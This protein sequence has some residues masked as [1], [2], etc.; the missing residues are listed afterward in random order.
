MSS[1]CYTIAYCAI[2]KGANCRPVTSLNLNEIFHVVFKDYAQKRAKN[3]V[4]SPVFVQLNVTAFATWLFFELKM[5]W[6]KVKQS[7]FQCTIILRV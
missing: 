7:K 3:R 4:E 2:A 1:T 6:T 5:N